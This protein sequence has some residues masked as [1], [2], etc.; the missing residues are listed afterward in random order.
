[1]LY[2]VSILNS[3]TINETLGGGGVDQKAQFLYDY[4]VTSYRPPFQFLPLHPLLPFLTSS[5]AAAVPSVIMAFVILLMDESPKYCL[6][7]SSLW[8][9]RY[10]P[11][12]GQWLITIYS[13]LS[14][15]SRLTSRY[16]EVEVLSSATQH[17]H[18][19]ITPP[20]SVSLPADNVSPDWWY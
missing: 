12:P 10:H 4:Y 19:P 20:N 16:G 5:P 17:F 14:S 1:M 8:N 15:C 9:P 13:A 3:L 6:V 7:S 2:S 18:F 11:T